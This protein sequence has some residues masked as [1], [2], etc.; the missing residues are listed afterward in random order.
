VGTEPVERIAEKKGGGISFVL[1]QARGKG[2]KQKGSA[3][4]HFKRKNKSKFTARSTGG[5]GREKVHVPGKTAEKPAGG[6]GGRNGMDLKGRGMR[7]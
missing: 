4:R 7:G 2:S 6:K 5:G 1:V 3:K